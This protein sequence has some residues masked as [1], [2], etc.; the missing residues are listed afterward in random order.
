MTEDLADKHEQLCPRKEFAIDVVRRLREAGFQA[1]WAGGC[2]RDALL[3]IDPKDYDV[4][5][6]ARPEQVI[7]LF[8]KRRT[9]PVGVSFGVVMVLGPD[10]NSGQIEVATF[11]TDGEYNDGRRPVEVTYCSPEEDA[12]RRDFTI[13]G[14]FIDPLSGNVIDYVEGKA[15]LQDRM[16][17][18]IGDPHQ[19][20]S[21]DK[22]RMLRAVR[23][24][25]TYDLRIDPDTM[26]AIS[27]HRHQ[28][29]QVSAERIAA[30]LRRMLSHGSR[31]TS[32]SLLRDS[33]LL[34]V[35]LPER[36]A[37]ADSDTA[38]TGILNDESHVLQALELLV[39]SRFE[40]ALALILATL[41]SDEA[42]SLSR[43]VST[44]R[45]QCRL[46]KLSNK[47]TEMIC[48]LADGLPLIQTPQ[49]RPLHVIKPLLASEYCD[50]LIAIV[51]A[52]QLATEEHS[53]DADWL[54]QYLDSHSTDQI[55]PAPLIDGSDLKARQVA[56][57]P[58]FKEILDRIRT[59][60][61]DE[62][63][64]TREQALERLDQLTSDE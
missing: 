19:R 44:I 14:M 12:K 54:K 60:Q 36:F 5:T 32:M 43:R 52:S 17:R 28:L 18:A 57:G 40:S 25:A 23:F 10:R 30:E 21:E 62:Q 35:V 53:H 24:A 11:R 3:D 2:V 33:G 31:S 7:E 64:N 1:L 16:L 29:N 27:H 9:V 50:E 59:E 8:G 42:D 4:A 22:L 34:P 38:R 37:A 41:R 49:H 61:L 47:E 55:N 45:S 20:F 15:D 6:D 63:I 39:S 13:N 26:S 56:S 48:W 46:L 51:R 58:R